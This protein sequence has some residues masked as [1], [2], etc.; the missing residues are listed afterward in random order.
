LNCALTPVAIAIRHAL[1]GVGSGL[2][3]S[4]AVAQSG[5]DPGGVEEIVVR[6]AALDRY[7]VE[8]N[9]LTKLTESIR[10]TPQSILERVA[11]RPRRD[12][13]ERSPAQRARHHAR[14]RRVQ[15]AG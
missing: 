5:G 12:V 3:A 13:A 2:F 9:A 7:R 15:L 4:H 1:I 14:R 11:R 8:D 6:E 10:D